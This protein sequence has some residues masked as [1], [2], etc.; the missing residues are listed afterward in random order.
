MR[1]WKKNKVGKV[2]MRTHDQMFNRFTKGVA[3]AANAAQDGMESLMPAFEKFQRI[4]MRRDRDMSE[5][6]MKTHNEVMDIMEKLG[7]N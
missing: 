3:G 1:T 5:I 7:D 4:T 6:V 2:M